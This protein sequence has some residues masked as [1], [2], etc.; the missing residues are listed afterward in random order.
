MICWTLGITEHHNAVD[1]VLALINL[2][3]LTGHVGRYG[4]GL[5]PLRGQNN[6]QGGGDMGALPDRLPGF[7]HVEND[8]LRARFDAE[9]GVPVP[10]KRGWHLSG[11][12]D[13]MER[14]DLTALY[15]IGENPMQSEADRTRRERLL[16]AAW[17]SSSSRTSSSRRPRRSRT[18]CCRPP[19]PGPRP[20]APSPTASGGSSGCGPP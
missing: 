10:P 15:V 1:N 13:A 5:N 14:G 20:R 16:L 12:F 17:T 6:V 4:S 18:S 11:M 9:W 7:Q 2:S 19:P 3:L 8:A